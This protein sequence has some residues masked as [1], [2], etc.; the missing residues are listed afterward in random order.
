MTWSD[1]LGNSTEAILLVAVGAFVGANLRYGVGLVVDSSLLSTA[2]VNVLGCYALGVLFYEGR[3][4][5]V[6]SERSRRVLGTGL[7]SSF[8]TYSTFVLDTVTAAPATGLGYLFGS[9]ALGFAGV[10]LGR[11]TV[12]RVAGSPLGA[13]EG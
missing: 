3:F 13:G 12:Q 1:L 2:A 11:E 10:V 8:T 9:Y 4:V 6:V 5:E 7:L